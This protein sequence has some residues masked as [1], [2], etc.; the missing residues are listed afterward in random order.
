MESNWIFFF[1]REIALIFDLPTSLLFVSAE[2][3]KLINLRFCYTTESSQ[4]RCLDVE[5]FGVKFDAPPESVSGMAD[6]DGMPS[7]EEKSLST[8]RYILALR[9]ANFSSGV[10]STAEDSLLGDAE[11]DWIDTAICCRLKD[12]VEELKGLIKELESRGEGDE[13]DYK[14]ARGL[15]NE[16]GASME[17]SMRPRV[18]EEALKDVEMISSKQVARIVSPRLPTNEKRVT[19]LRCVEEMQVSQDCKM[20][21]GLAGQ[22][23][24]RGNGLNMRRKAKQSV[25]IVGCSVTAPR[26]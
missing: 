24:E 4:R 11:A 12:R 7:E 1:F 15:H 23:E 6:F 18:V 26:N 9:K 5:M 3:A 2:P 10:I 20:L 25:E 13:I 14:G 21:L 17:A 16:R 8:E 22:V 19:V